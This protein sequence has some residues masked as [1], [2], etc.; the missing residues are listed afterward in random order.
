[1]AHALKY[2]KEITMSDGRT[3]R[4]ELHKYDWGGEAQE[5]GKV[6]QAL[7]LEIQGTNNNIDSP[8]IKTSLTMSFVDAPDAPDAD[9]KKCGNWDEF[10]TA[11]STEWMVILKAKDRGGSFRSIWGGYVT[12][13]SFQESLRYRGTVTIVA[14]DNIGHLQD[15]PFNGS[16]NEDGM[17]SL[18]YLINE[19]WSVIASP[20][21]LDWR[22]QNDNMWWLRAEDVIAYD[23]YMNVSAFK[24]KTWYEAVESALYSYGLVLRYTG[25][26]YFTIS[27]L[28][29]MPAMGYEFEYEVEHRVP[30]FQASA[31]RELTP[32]VK[33]IEE[34]DKYELESASRAEMGGSLIFDESEDTASMIVTFLDKTTEA[35]DIPVYRIENQENDGWGNDETTMF[36]NPD[37]YGSSNS[38]I[39]TQLRKGVA[40]AASTDGN[41]SVWYA[42][43]LF[44]EDIKLEVRFGNI[45]AIAG[46]N[47]SQLVPAGGP[48][49]FTFA[50]SVEQNGITSYLADSGWVNEIHK[51]TLELSS[52]SIGLNIPLSAF[53]GIVKVKIHIYQVGY[54]WSSNFSTPGLY[55]II[56]S[57]SFGQMLSLLEKNTVNTVYNQA[58]N[59]ILTREPKFAPA[60]NETFLPQ[61]IRNGIFRKSGNRYLPTPEWNWYGSAPQQLAVYNHLQLLC[62]HAK[63]NN[64]IRGTIVDTDLTRIRVIW[65]WEGAEHMLISGTFD[66][67]A[68]RIDGAVLREFTR[69][70]DVWSDI[71]G[72]SYPETEESTVTDTESNSGSGSGSGTSDHTELY[73]RDRENQHP[74][75]AITGLLAKLEEITLF[76]L[77]ADG[78][79]LTPKDETLGIVAAF[80]SA[81]DSNPDAGNTASSFN[82]S[83]M[84]ELLANDDSSK[85]INL[86]HLTDAL[87]SG[88]YLT[89]AAADLLYAPLGEGGGIS[90]GQVFYGGNLGADALASLSS[91][92]KDRLQAILDTI[93]LTNDTNPVTGYEANE[94]IYYIV[95]ANQ[96]FAGLELKVGDWLIS[97]G[98]SWQKIDNT[99]AVTSVNGKTGAVVL[100][101]E[102]IGGL[103]EASSL[104]ETVGT[105]A[106]RPKDNRGIITESYVSAQDSNP[107]ANP[108][109]PSFDADQMWSYLNG[110]VQYNGSVS[111]VAIAAKFIPTLEVTNIYG[112][113]VELDGIRG[114]MSTKASSAD[115][116]NYLPLSGGTMTGAITL[117]NTS[118]AWNSVG[119]IFKGGSRIGENNNGGLGIYG[120]GKVYIRP[121]SVTNASSYGLIISDT[122][123]TFNDYSL[124]HS[125][126]IG[127]QSVANADTLDGYHASSFMRFSISGSYVDANM[128]TSELS[129]LAAG[130]GGIEFWDSVEGWYN[131][132]VGKVTAANGFVGSLKGNAASATKLETARTI[133]GQSFDGTGNVG[134]VLKVTGVAS[135][136][137]YF[138]DNGQVRITADGTNYT[139][140]I[141]AS[142]TGL[143][144]IQSSQIG[145]G[146][147]PLAINNMGGNVL[148]G[149]TT[150]NGNKLQ[151]QGPVSAYGG[152]FYTDYGYVIKLTSTGGW[153]RRLT[154][155]ANEGA[156][157]AQIAGAYGN[158]S[159]LN[160][161]YYGGSYTN[162][163]MA[164]LPSGRVLIGGTTD[165]NYLL[166][167]NGTFRTA[168]V[169]KIGSSLEV[170]G[171]GAF[172]GGIVVDEDAEIYGYLSVEGDFTIY[173]STLLESLQVNGASIFNDTVE[174]QADAYANNFRISTKDDSYGLLPS[175]DNWNQ[176][177]SSSLHW[178]RSYIN[179][180]YCSKLEA[181]SSVIS[182]G[183]VSAQSSNSNSSVI[184]S[185]GSGLVTLNLPLNDVTDGTAA[186]YGLTEQVQN[187]I[188]TGAISRAKI[189]G[190]I[191]TIVYVDENLIIIGYNM[192]HS[193]NEDDWEHWKIYGS[194][195]YVDIIYYV[196]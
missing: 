123:V 160:Y 94:G 194:G 171:P 23:T 30:V 188:R 69:Y 35:R 77:T 140:G 112:L 167:V 67:L 124:I 82:E 155:N 193:G 53:S 129:V 60:L 26:N 95:S 29:S 153:A 25:N 37:V 85:Q 181:D 143:G 50:V 185:G 177:G 72:S 32:A 73:N 135:S 28:R 91:A 66:F 103:G 175:A 4:L 70:E 154:V 147:I 118:V 113:S 172:R 42:Q 133:W 131:F 45:V 47:N 98:I 65:S 76:K 58:N 114:E 22:G 101:A 105:V 100:T 180:M 163:H 43:T 74:M 78:K 63:P 46:V 152:Y 17:I 196:V 195:T 2:F 68:E 145:T 170:E 166:D 109:T 15:F 61:I 24:D 56:E 144:V 125:G 110:S 5:I 184:Y 134:G 7:K 57:L 178:Y 179:N 165:N 97:T 142:A 146:A 128:G 64:I 96:T 174:V 102:D 190:A 183:S 8:I 62:F 191:Y 117:Q 40:V 187:G 127:S 99:D 41:S 87:T 126:N 130:D 161:L 182:H 156:V 44:A 106:L 10:Y 120:A 39:E 121:S 139:L 52:D 34:T 136:A 138:A 1:M 149:T 186:N 21:T 89:K 90:G 84:W 162:P 189:Y 12:P 119:I 137:N 38:S 9:T 16:S 18:Y 93:T 157:S 132:K 36:L 79:A 54:S 168:G 81:S 20:M 107:S 158:G 86:A 55:A 88:G 6:V 115:L 51:F 150:D 173:G 164:I 122:D 59:V 148:I 48:D 176:I 159:T 13:D 111:P 169:A 3:V 80:L 33:R 92:A 192:E 83:R 31:E 151:V 49:S 19:A 141:G 75:K 71:P 104:W 11:S 27:S 116:S 14:R 108:I